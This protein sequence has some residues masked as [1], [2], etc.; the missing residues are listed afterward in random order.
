MRPLRQDDTIAAVA[1]PPGRGAI[2]VVRVS[3]PESGSLIR[4]LFRPEGRRRLVRSRAVLGRLIDP[5]DGSIIDQAV[6]TTYRAPR[7]YTGQDMAEISVHG[8]PVIV[9]DIL[10]LLLHSGARLA[11]PGE[12]TLR[13]FLAGKLDLTQAEAVRDVVAARTLHQ[14]R[15]AE[16]QLAG[17]ISR[18][19]QPV[20]DELIAIICTLETE[21]EFGEDMPEE[22]LARGLGERLSAVSKQLASITAGFRY[23]RL[24]Q[25]GFSLAIIGGANVGK[26]SLFNR[27]VGEERAIVTELPG[28]TRDVLREPIQI[29]GLPV[30]VF[31]TAGLRASDDRIERLGIEKSAVAAADADVIVFV[32]DASRGWELADG[33]RLA[34]VRP[35][36]VLLALNKSDLPIRTTPSFIQAARPATPVVLVSARTGAGLDELRRQIRLLVAPEDGLPADD[37]IIVGLRQQ[38]CIRE[39]LQA[40]ESAAAALAAGESEEFLLYHLRRSLAALDTLTGATAVEELLGRI[41]D[42]FCIGK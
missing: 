14:A 17:S 26:S 18:S 2:A 1:T 38:T 32:I 9:R 15:V 27:L 34:A 22:H 29:E 41:F 31:D 20:K 6:V 13:A 25:D 8:S 16:R 23:A 19:L 28:T 42:T 40:L 30:T 3:G 21:V 24:L 35:H 39:C 37:A 33:E 4:R 5:T 10:R 36:G 7:S 11:E 12:F